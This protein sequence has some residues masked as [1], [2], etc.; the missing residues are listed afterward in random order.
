SIALEDAKLHQGELL[1]WGQKSKGAHF[2]LTL[3]KRHGTSIQSLP[4][5]VIPKDDVSTVVN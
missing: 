2:V 4:I 5:N 1:A 3:P